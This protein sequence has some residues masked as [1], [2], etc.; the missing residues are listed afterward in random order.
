MKMTTIKHSFSENDMKVYASGDKVG[1]LATINYEGLPHISL[2]TTIQA[3]GSKE[4]ILGEFITGSSKKFIQKNHNIAF[5]V[6]TFSRKMWRGK[7]AWTHLAKEGPE[8]ER[9]NLI[10]MFRYNTYF[11]INTVHYF[12]LVEVSEPEPLPMAGIIREA[13]KTMVGRRSLKTGK[14][15]HILRPFIEKMFNQITSLKFLSF[16]G[17]NGYPVLIPLIQCQAADSRRLAFSSGIYTDEL[18]AIPVGS[19][20]AVFCM[21]FAIED[22]LIRGTFNGFRKS[23]FGDIGTIDIEWVYNSMPPAIGQIYPELDLKPVTNF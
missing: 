19:V 16:I 6:M 9:L 10:P 5:L 20:V 22:I 14:D 13:L 8:Y 21:N 2:I 4:L 15:E 3:N 18:K 23:L 11:G 12:D 17:N 1:L 7:A